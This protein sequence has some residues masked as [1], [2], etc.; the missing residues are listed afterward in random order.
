MSTISKPNTFSS[1]TTISSSKMNDNF[2]TIYNEFNGSIAAAN[3][4][5]SA[6]T[7]AK[8]AASAVTDAK[9]AFTSLP[10]TNGNEFIKFAQTAS[11]VNEVTVTNNATGSAPSLS[12]TGGDTNIN[13]SLTG[14][15]N[16]YV[17]QQIPSQSITT[18]TYPTNML[19]QVGW[20]FADVSSATNGTT[21]VTFPVAFTA[22]PYIQCTFAGKKNGSDPTLI[23]DTTSSHND[24]TSARAY[25]PT[26]TTFSAEINTETIF[27]SGDRALFTWSATGLV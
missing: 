24:T 4:A 8:I 26:T 25:T 20:G 14:K 7:T 3:L 2:D 15:G 1:S 18:N 9:T 6:V 23:T 16:G 10:D 17:V 11:A 27:S 13:L 5:S 22:A 19:T 21:T 12:A